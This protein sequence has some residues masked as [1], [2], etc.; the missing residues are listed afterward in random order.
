MNLCTLTE[1]KSFYGKTSTDIADD[2]L[3]T[4]LIVRYSAF[5][6][7]YIGKNIISREHTDYY[8][9]KGFNVLFVDQYPITSISGIWD[10]SDWSWDDSNLISSDNYRIADSNRI[11]FRSTTLADEDQNIKIIYTAGYSAVPEDLRQACVVEVL[12]AYKHRKEVDI[13]S[14]SL[15]DGS[16]SYI[17]RNLLAQTKLILNRYKKVI[18]L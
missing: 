16:V 11:L 1:L 2:V 9:G 8:D 5:F 10:S 6:E 15:S 13:V 7:S 14:K 3:I 4:N 18:I 17:E 12:R